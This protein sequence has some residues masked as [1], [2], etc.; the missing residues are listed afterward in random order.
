M[1]RLREFLLRCRE[2]IA[3]RRRLRR[4]RQAAKTATEDV[5][6][7]QGPYEWPPGM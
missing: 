1:E 2:T 4:E 6:R 3:T 5:A 7:G